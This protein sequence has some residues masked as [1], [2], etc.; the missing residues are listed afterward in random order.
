MEWKASLLCKRCQRSVEIFESVV[1]A[2]RVG[3]IDGTVCL[4]FQQI[5]LE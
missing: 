5:F 2:P 1:T 3:V 4:F